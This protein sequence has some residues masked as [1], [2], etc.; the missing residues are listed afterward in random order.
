MFQ[1]DTHFNTDKLNEIFEATELVTFCGHTHIPV[2]IRSDFT[3]YVPRHDTDEF[4]LESGFK[5]IVNVGSL[6]QPRDRDP[7]TCCGIFD[8]ETRAFSYHRLEYDIS[9]TRRKILDA[10]LAAVFAERL[11][12]G[13]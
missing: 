9:T 13:M 3:T 2:V 5:Y 10:G 7:R 12:V 8:T 4:R 1:E 6:G 11:L